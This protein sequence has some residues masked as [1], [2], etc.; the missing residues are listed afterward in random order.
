[1]RLR[2]PTAAVLLACAAVGAGCGGDA[3]SKNAY[4]DD[5]QRAQ[6]SFV[7]RFDQVRERLTAT[8]TLAQD[9]ATLGDFGTATAAFVTA[10]G[11]VTP[12]EDVRAEHERL[13]AAV[14]EYE[15]QVERAASRL[16]GGS[17]QDRAQVRTELSSGVGSTQARIA[18]AIEEI[19]AGLRD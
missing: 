6:R 14:K 8:S 1:M 13:V 9:R 16:R 3:D 12:P 4:V 2:R 18:T 5:V 15:R 11:R 19:N 10:L 7:T 17:V